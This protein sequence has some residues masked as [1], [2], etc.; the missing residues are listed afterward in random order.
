VYLS[1]LISNK[2]RC[3]VTLPCHIYVL[4]PDIFA[5]NYN[6][7]VPKALLQISSSLC[8]LVEKRIKTTILKVTYIYTTFFKEINFLK[9][10]LSWFTNVHCGSVYQEA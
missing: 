5:I 9:G 1:I 7:S 6:L 8:N 3:D 4:F 2:C 10:L